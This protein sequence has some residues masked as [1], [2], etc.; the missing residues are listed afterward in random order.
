MPDAI[1]PPTLNV[2]STHEC[3]VRNTNCSCGIA[4]PF[5]SSSSFNPPTSCASVFP[6]FEKVGNMLIGLWLFDMEWFFSGFGIVV[7]IVVFSF[8][9]EV[10]C[11]S[12]SISYVKQLDSAFFAISF[13]ALLLITDTSNSWGSSY[14]KSINQCFQFIQLSVSYWFLRLITNGSCG[15]VG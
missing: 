4:L 6:A 12:R 13:A 2:C 1:K 14:F 9:W 8:F 11:Y 5:T 7:V 15:L 3:P 10:L